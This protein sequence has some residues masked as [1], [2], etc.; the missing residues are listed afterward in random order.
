MKYGLTLCWFLACILG[1]SSLL[2]CD[3]SADD[4]QLRASAV[5]NTELESTIGAIQSL[6]GIYGDG[7]SNQGESWSLFVNGY[8][9]YAQHKKLEPIEESCKLEVTEIFRRE[10]SYS[11]VSPMILTEQFFKSPIGFSNHPRRVSLF[12][13]NARLTFLEPDHTPFIE[14]FDAILPNAPHTTTIPPYK[15]QSSFWGGRPGNGLPMVYGANFAGLSVFTSQQHYITGTQGKVLLVAQSMLA[16]SYAILDEI[17][18]LS[19]EDLTQA[20]KHST[21]VTLQQPSKTFFIDGEALR[22]KG[23]HLPQ[24]G[25]VRHIVL[26]DEQSKSYQVIT[27]SLFPPLEY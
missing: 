2:N 11:A 6:E 9:G 13:L 10:T 14:I 16:S 17:P 4:F 25:V 7:C 24:K 12:Y 27:L 19:E 1:P 18:S 22:L 8:E 5:H 15:I 3:S 20:L 23:M 26:M 21:K